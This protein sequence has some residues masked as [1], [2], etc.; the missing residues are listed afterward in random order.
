VLPGIRMEDIGIN[1][2]AWKLELILMENGAL[3]ML[4]FYPSVNDCLLK[5]VKWNAINLLGVI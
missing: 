2:C 1:R 5:V 3:W 4:I